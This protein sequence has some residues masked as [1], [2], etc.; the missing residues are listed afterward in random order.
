MDVLNIINDLNV[1]RSRELDE[2]RD[3][4]ARFI[5]VDDDGSV[6][7]LDVLILINFLNE[8]RNRGEGEQNPQSNAAHVLVWS[9]ATFDASDDIAQRRMK[10]ANGH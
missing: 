7:P 6:T 2:N 4:N 1:L 9:D 10:R 5:D 3:A 8:S